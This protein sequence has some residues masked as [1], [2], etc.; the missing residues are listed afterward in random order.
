MVF[1]RQS[2][3]KL[4]SLNRFSVAFPISPTEKPRRR[5]N[6]QRD[7]VKPTTTIASNLMRQECEQ[8][9]GVQ[10][11]GTELLSPVPSFLLHTIL[12]QTVRADLS[13]NSAR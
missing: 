10:N 7:D 5:V 8:Q 12:S 13:Q 2:K 6:L 1:S 3:K 9:D 11:V 4:I